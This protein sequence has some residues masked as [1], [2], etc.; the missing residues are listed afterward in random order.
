MSRKSKRKRQLEKEES[1]RYYIQTTGGNSILSGGDYVTVQLAPTTF[2][3]KMVSDL[4]TGERVVYD[5]RQVRTTLEDV[6]GVMERYPLYR[7]AIDKVFEVDSRGVRI[8]RFRRALME[9]LAEKR[10]DCGNRIISP[11]NLEQKILNEGEHMFSGVEYDIG[12]NYIWKTIQNSTSSYRQNISEPPSLETIKLWEK[13]FETSGRI[14]VGP[15]SYHILKILSDEF[16]PPFSEFV[17]EP[18]DPDGFAR[19]RT[20]WRVARQQVMKRLNE[21][22]GLTMFTEEEKERGESRSNVSREVDS[23]VSHLMK[24]IDSSLD[25]YM[26]SHIT[27]DI[28]DRVVH[29]IKRRDRL[30]GDGIITTN[31]PQLKNNIGSYLRVY[32]DFDLVSKCYLS[33]VYNS[34]CALPL[35]FDLRVRF[36]DWTLI[37]LLLKFGEPLD[38]TSKKAYDAV[39]SEARQTDKKK[40]IGMEQALLRNFEDLG[41]NILSGIIDQEFDYSKGTIL[42]DVETIFR[43]RRALPPLLWEYQRID[44]LNCSNNP[45]QLARIKN[46]LKNIR[47]TIKRN[48]NIPLG[49]NGISEKMGY[50]FTTYFIAQCGS[51]PEE[52]SNDP[53]LRSLYESRIKPNDIFVQWITR[54]PERALSILPE[55][56]DFFLRTREYTECVLSRYGLEQMLPI[57]EPTFLVERIARMNGVN[58]QIPKEFR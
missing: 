17:G 27:K 47:N 4:N 32:E 44:N 31:I 50:F 5:N 39:F 28:S 34:S 6:E 45:Q 56:P 53:T 41:N 42:K 49:D 18:E 55:D 14:R 23:I 57:M 16:G 54:S 40:N 11:E 26:V 24:T 48:Y 43:L 3:R 29:D 20:I 21:R 25:S 15:G 8:S 46:Q 1:T 30:L 37:H 2:I 22:R 19:N 51:N 7:R 52:L 10:D 38:S 13:G 9:T 35:P 12:A 33:C 36:G 58:L